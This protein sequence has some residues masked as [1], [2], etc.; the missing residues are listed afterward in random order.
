LQ[1]RLASRSAAGVSNVA[2]G[3]SRAHLSQTA[4]PHASAEER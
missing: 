3:G 1:L 2:M 4:Q